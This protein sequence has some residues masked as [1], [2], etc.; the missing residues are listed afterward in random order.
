MCV[1]DLLTVDNVEDHGKKLTNLCE[2]NHPSL[3]LLNMPTDLTYCYCV[4]LSSLLVLSISFF[5]LLLS[6]L[7]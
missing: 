4:T 3:H 7:P 5:S 6:S 1:F 2:A